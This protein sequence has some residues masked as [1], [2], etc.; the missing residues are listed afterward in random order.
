[1]WCGSCGAGEA[2]AVAAEGSDPDAAAGEAV[3]PPWVA[4]G[5]A[6]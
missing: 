4:A 2:A 3:A 6:A 1:M 5:W